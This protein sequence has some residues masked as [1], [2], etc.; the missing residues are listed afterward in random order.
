MRITFYIEDDD[1]LVW[2]VRCIRVL[3]D[4]KDIAI[5][6]MKDSFFKTHAS[7]TFKQSILLIIPVK[8]I[9]GV[10]IRVLYAF[11]QHLICKKLYKTA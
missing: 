11:C 3:Y 1:L 5:L 8:T 2:I 4:I 6:D 10:Y 7:R 9:H